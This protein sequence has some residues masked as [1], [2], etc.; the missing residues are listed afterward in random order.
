MIKIFLII[1]FIFSFISPTF[2]IEELPEGTIPS[3]KIY[4]IRLKTG[5]IISGY[6]NEIISSPKQGIKFETEIGIAPIYFDQIAEIRL[7]NDYYRYDHRVFLLPTASP[8]GDND[9]VGLYELAFVYAGLGIGDYV[10]VTAGR[11]FIPGFSSKEQLTLINLKATIYNVDWEDAPGGMTLAFGANQVYFD[12]NQITNAYFVSSFEMEKS[13]LTGGL[14]VKA[15]GEDYIDLINYNQF[16]N[17]FNTNTNNIPLSGFRYPTGSVGIMIGLDKKIERW[18][19]VHFIGELWNGDLS[20]PSN[21][22]LL[23]GIRLFNTSFSADIGLVLFTAPVLA[24]FASF[25]WTPF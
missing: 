25:N 11:S 8:V 23:A 13:T 21:T 15:G 10:S 19:G 17:N 22:G 2:A 16:N 14:F 24:P 3:D 12:N 18:Q 5:D 1:T 9:F 7:S 6:I 20:K 4:I